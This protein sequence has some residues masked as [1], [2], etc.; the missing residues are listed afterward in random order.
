MVFPY[1]STRRLSL[2]DKRFLISSQ[3][4]VNPV[5]RKGTETFRTYC[6]AGPRKEWDCLM[7]KRP[8]EKYITVHVMDRYIQ[9]GCGIPD[10]GGGPGHYSIRYTKQGH[11]MTL[12]D[13]SEEN[14][15]FA[16]KIALRYGLKMV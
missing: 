13:L 1:R 14:M 3:K 4:G 2:T 9:Q 7:K 12:S 10:I 8:H 16:R 6:N 15:C 5:I 11:P